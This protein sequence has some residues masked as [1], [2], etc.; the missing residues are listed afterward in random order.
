MRYLI[1][2]FQSCMIYVL[3][4]HFQ[5]YETERKLFRTLSEDFMPE[6][7]KLFDLKEKQQRNKLL[8][9][10]N[11]RALRSHE[12]DLNIEFEP[13]SK[14]KLNNQA[15]MSK[16]KVKSKADKE[17]KKSKVSNL[18]K[19]NIE[20]DVPLP[21]SQPVQKKGRQT[22]NS[23]A[24]AV[25][26]IVIDTRDETLDMVNRKGDKKNTDNYSSLRYNDISFGIEEEE[27]QVG[28]HKVLESVKD[29]EEAWPFVDPV[30]EEYAPRYFYF[31]SDSKDEN[32][33]SL[34]KL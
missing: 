21:V 25:G 1:F 31:F 11:S 3:K 24:S 18:K 2:H 30:D 4:N 12:P 20:E 9:R 13:N 27:R 34:Q 17:L 33:D 16:M 14:S 22:N 7:P 28:M 5:E 8:L 23:L 29:H 26:Q 19:S 32:S 10:N 15:T 6:I